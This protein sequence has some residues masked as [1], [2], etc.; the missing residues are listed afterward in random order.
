MKLQESESEYRC[1]TLKYFFTKI[2]AVNPRNMVETAVTG[3][4]HQ[5]K[6]HEDM[7]KWDFNIGDEISYN[8]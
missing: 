8:A 5:S 7:N 2:E 6:A 1:F 4:N 3:E